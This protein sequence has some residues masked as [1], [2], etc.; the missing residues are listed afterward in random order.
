M[1][2]TLRTAITLGTIFALMLFPS[3]VAAQTPLMSIDRDADLSPAGALITI[4]GSITCD[5][6]DSFLVEVWV[7]QGDGPNLETAFSQLGGADCVGAPQVW[8][9][10]ARSVTGRFHKGK[11]TVK[12]HGYLFAPDSF[13]EFLLDRTIRLK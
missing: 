7:T 13:E 5:T 8:E 12:V 10:L 3:V 9:S 11:A 6:G 4:S 1:R 2:R